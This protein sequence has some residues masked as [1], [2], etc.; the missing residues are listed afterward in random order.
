MS[1]TQQQSTSLTLTI[2]LGAQQ[3]AIAALERLAALGA[4][5]RYDLLGET[6][7]YD[8]A[9]WQAGSNYLQGSP[10]P[11]ATVRS[12]GLAWESTPAGHSGPERLRRCVERYNRQTA[13]ATTLAAGVS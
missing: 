8:P 12:G 6:R 3:Q 10:R 4:I 9:E 2:D 7:Y 1:D 13:A 5:R 11:V